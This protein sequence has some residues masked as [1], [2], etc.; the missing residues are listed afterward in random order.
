ME[1]SHRQ[2][3]RQL[4]AELEQLTSDNDI[5]LEILKKEMEDLK[6]REERWKKVADLNKK[7]SDYDSSDVGSRDQS[8]EVEALK[9]QMASLQSQY[10]DEI[11][12]LK[13]KLQT[14]IE[15]FNEAIDKIEEQEFE[16][17]E[18]VS[19]LRSSFDKERKELLSCHKAEIER[20][21]SSYEEKLKDLDTS[22]HSPGDAESGCSSQKE[23]YEK[24]ISNL[25][26]KVKNSEK[27]LEER[28]AHMAKDMLIMKNEFERQLDDARNMYESEREELEHN[29]SD[30]K[31]EANDARERYTRDIEQMQESFRKEKEGMQNTPQDLLSE[32]RLKKGDLQ[33]KLEEFEEEVKQLKAN[34]EKERTEFLEARELLEN[35]ISD[36]EKDFAEKEETTRRELTEEHRKEMETV[37]SEYVRRLQETEKRQ[38][39]KDD[40]REEDSDE[41][42]LNQPAEQEIKQL[43]IQHVKEIEQ[44]NE[45]LESLQ[46]EKENLKVEYDTVVSDLNDE[47]ENSKRKEDATLMFEKME[48][49]KQNVAELE[50]EVQ[51]LS[52][53]AVKSDEELD[54][55]TKLAEMEYELHALKE[56]REEGNMA[57]LDYKAKVSVLE[58]QLDNRG[59][60]QGLITQQDGVKEKMSHLENQV[61]ILERDNQKIR[62]ELE[63][64]KTS[65]QLLREQV[66]KLTV[67]KEEEKS[68]VTKYDGQVYELNNELQKNKAMYEEKLEAERQKVANVKVEKE[69]LESALNEKLRENKLK[70]EK[71][72]SELGKMEDEHHSVLDS[73]QAMSEEIISKLHEKIEYLQQEGEK[74]GK[75]KELLSQEVDKLRKAS[76]AGE[77]DNIKIDRYQ[78]QVKELCEKIRSLENSR[79]RSED[80]KQNLLEEIENLRLSQDTLTAVDENVA[81]TPL[82]ANLEYEQQM[83]D[84]AEDY[85][86]RI[87]KLETEL[88]DERNKS[89]TKSKRIESICKEIETLRENLEQER[90]SASNSQTRLIKFQDRHEDEVKSLKKQ[91]EMNAKE[92]EAKN[93]SMEEAANLQLSNTIKNLEVDLEA[94][95]QTNDDQASR[96]ANL[97]TQ[98]ENAL[99]TNETQQGEIAKL[100]RELEEFQQQQIAHEASL[101]A[102][103][104][105][106][107]QEHA[108]TVNHLKAELDAAHELNR[109]QQEE[110]NKVKHE[111]EEFE[112]HQIAHEPNPKAEHVMRISET[113]EAQKQEFKRKAREIAHLKSELE[114]ALQTNRNQTQ[115]ITKLK[116]EYSELQKTKIRLEEEIGRKTEEMAKL[117]SVLDT[118]QKGRERVL[119]ETEKHLTH[120][121]QAEQEKINAQRLITNLQNEIQ[122]LNGELT[123]GKDRYDAYVL[124]SEKSRL[125][126]HVEVEKLNKSLTESEM[127]KSKLYAEI[128]TWKD[129]LGKIQEK[130]NKLKEKCISLK[131]K[132]K[133]EK[134]KYDE[135]LLTP[136]FEMGLQTSL[137]EPDDLNQTKEQLSSSMREQ[138]RLEEELETLQRHTHKAKTEIQALRRANEVLRKQNQLLYLETESLKGAGYG[139]GVDIPLLQQQNEQ[140]IQDKENLEIENRY[141]KEALAEREKQDEERR[142]KDDYSNF[143]KQGTDTEKLDKTEREYSKLV[144]ENDFLLKQG[145]RLQSEVYQL[146]SEIQ[147]LKQREP[148][149]STPTGEV[150][151]LRFNSEAIQPGS[152]FTLEPPPEPSG[153]KAAPKTPTEVQLFV[154]EHQRLKEQLV[155]L[156]RL[157]KSKED[158]LHQ[159]NSSRREIV[160]GLGNEREMLMAQCESMSEACE[161]HGRT[162]SDGLNS[163]QKVYSAGYFMTMRFIHAPK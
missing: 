67:E 124:Q 92:Y 43:K 19:E 130:Y 129:E 94:A 76:K 25:K 98:L 157:L 55:K 133:E 116:S 112:R 79:Q 156:Q 5:E 90:M 72:T 21:E 37:I 159:K 120:M 73:H 42:V 58:G 80:E 117:F 11:T 1:Q 66:D 9:E 68:L 81:A 122:T 44:L 56:E 45:S 108:K 30:V 31:R 93:F 84:L 17:Q 145:K 97:R 114:G 47:L 33:K 10:E 65:V 103:Q 91:L 24:Q 136:R 126:D 123:K 62:S 38:N 118:E 143:E 109:Q 138:V 102:E 105:M 8:P 6:L 85:D 23:E 139:V 71:L 28:Q 128:E 40:V 54:L 113:E 2:E 141:L 39:Q 125:Q 36:Q 111:L 16:F 82:T 161:P 69:R 48:S 115:E 148:W 132:R 88:Q 131:Q 153:K 52:A 149:A 51:R 7:E 151:S 142:E 135:A 13:E 41:R 22:L 75:D 20:L 106:A 147:S 155:V 49:Y 18:N 29:L 87:Q 50:A 104:F 110:I 160:D 163:P 152:P 119:K 77:E 144:E 57:L 3:T 63:D 27:T 89:A 61:G 46:T 134:E 14:Q 154:E 53:A 158:E 34:L 150:T 140:L 35:M 107:S 64:S 74:I 86:T 26:E 32:Q 70:V 4:K 162:E 96:L 127:D 12:V 99:Q 83:R 59:V 15:K 60:E 137:L 78:E 121:R 100:N 146:E 95:L 101:T